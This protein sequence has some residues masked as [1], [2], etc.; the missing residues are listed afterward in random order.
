MDKDILI[1]KSTMSREISLII[2]EFGRGTDFLCIDDDVN[3]NG[4]V[5]VI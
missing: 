5:V 3:E 1:K 4:G 2:R